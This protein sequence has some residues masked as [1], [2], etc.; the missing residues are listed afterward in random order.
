MGVYETTSEIY[1]DLIRQDLK[2]HN[3]TAREISVKL[4]LDGLSTIMRTYYY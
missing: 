1:Y 2:H 3:I 4:A